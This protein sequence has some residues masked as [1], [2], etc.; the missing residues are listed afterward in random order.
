MRKIIWILVLIAVVLGFFAYQSLLVMPPKPSEDSLQTEEDKPF[1]VPEL[2]LSGVGSLKELRER[3]QNLECQITY[4]SLQYDG[5]VEGTY[6]VSDGLIRGDFIIPAKDLGGQ[7]VSSMIIDKTDMYVW[8]LIGEETYGLKSPLKQ[9]EA[10][11]TL[12]SNEP[13]PLDGQ[14][15]YT[16]TKWAVVD[17]SVF[18]PP[19]NVEFK[20]MEAAVS[21]GMEYGIEL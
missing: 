17:G 8:S 4:E 11:S 20:S 9:T 10:S 1:S 3:N 7:I 14:V 6:F 2:P 16:C 19:Q 13:V 15:R 12:T 5:V 18:V 21:G